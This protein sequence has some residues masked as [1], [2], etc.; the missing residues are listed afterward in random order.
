MDS[1]AQINGNAKGLGMHKLMVQYR[2][3]IFSWQ[4]IFYCIL[5][6]PLFLHLDDFFHIYSSLQVNN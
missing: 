6:F 1:M 5:L 2:V 4:W 3:Y